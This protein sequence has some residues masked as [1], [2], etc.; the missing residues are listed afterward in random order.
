MEKKRVV[1]IGLGLIGGSIALAIRKKHPAVTIIGID[2]DQKQLKIACALGIIDEASNEIKKE[3]ENADLIV[4][5]CPVKATETFLTQM[6]SWSLKPTVLVTD[7]G[8][9]K[10]SIMDAAAGLLAKGIHFIGAHPMAG[11]HKSGVQAAKVDLFENA[12]YLI[13]PADNQPDSQAVV[14]E[15]KQWFD[16]TVSKFLIL[17]PAEHD[18]ITGMLSHLPHIIAA[19]LV[20][21]TT[22]FT[23]KYPL[24]KRLAAGGFRDMTRIASSDP[25]MWTDILLSNNQVLIQL[26]TN[27]RD[28][29]SQLLEMLESNDSKAIYHFFDQ[30]KETR[31]AMPIHKEGALPAFFDLFIDVPDYPGVISEVTGYLAQEE[32]SLINLK[33]LETR[34]EINGILQLT[35]QNQ[36]DLKQAK[37]CI[38]KNS[39][40]H[41][42]NK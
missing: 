42:Y 12:Y 33:I 29:M 16:G 35:F 22:D 34:E 30:A 37:S 36:E 23:V 14:E 41:C 8:S 10:G 17:S 11:S 1:I 13:T 31:D 3:A 2:L 7:T 28:E 25:T 19:S 38:Q 26:V 40:Y 15:F 4:F 39:S 20:N 18:Q 21:Q 24:T 27:W 9:T 6:V 32:I 5:S